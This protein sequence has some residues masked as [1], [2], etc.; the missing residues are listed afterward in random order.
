MSKDYTPLIALP[1]GYIVL[2]RADYDSIME[3]LNNVKANA[4]EDLRV[5]ND[6]VAYLHKMLEEKQDEIVR[7][8]ETVDDIKAEKRN[9]FERINL[10]LKYNGELEKTLAVYKEYMDKFELTGLF[11]NWKKNKDVYT[12]SENHEEALDASLEELREPGP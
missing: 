5:L 10:E 8:Q 12:F 9:M 3:R 1:P 6:D 11:E 4:Y 7:L 2:S